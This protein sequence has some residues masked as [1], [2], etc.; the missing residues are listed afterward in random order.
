MANI[1]LQ[2]YFSFF[3]KRARIARS[4]GY[5]LIGRAGVPQNTIPF[6]RIT[7]LLDAA[8]PAEDCARFN[9][10]VIGDP[11]LASDDHAIFYDRA[12]G[13]TG[14]RRNDHVF[15]NVYVVA[16]VHQVIDFRAAR[17]RVTSSAPRS[18]VELA[19]I[20]TSSSISRRPIWGI[21]VAA[22]FAS[23]T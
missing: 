21:F 19:P 18:I 22:G 20:S 3:R 12:S 23:G 7:L 5:S 9:V 15:A 10:H 11:Y 16:D 6:P 17:M 14:L 8:L 1:I 4:S 2:D 13:D